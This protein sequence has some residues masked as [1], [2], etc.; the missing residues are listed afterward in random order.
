MVQPGQFRSLAEH[1][2]EDSAAALRDWARANDFLIR[3]PARPWRSS[4]GYSGAT[5]HTIVLERDHVAE[6]L[7]VKR[8][9]PWPQRIHR[10]QPAGEPGRHRYALEHDPSDFSRDHL[11]AQ[12]FPAIMTSAGHIL[13]FQALAADGLPCVSLAELAPAVLPEA[14]ALVLG[15]LVGSWNDHRLR[16][17]AGT[18]ATVLH[19]EVGGTFAAGGTV[20]R[21]A[22]RAALLDIAVDWITLVGD[23]R[24]FPNPVLLALG[25][26]P[27][28][29]VPVD[30]V[31]GRAHGDL[32]L[33]NV[34]V[35]LAANG[36][37]LIPEF[38]I[39]DLA[40]ACTSGCL[41]RDLLTLMLS[42]I[43]LNI[44]SLPERRLDELIDHVL[45]A[46]GRSGT[47][48]AFRV[49]TAVCTALQ[50]GVSAAGQSLSGNLKLQRLLSTQA[51]SLAFTAYERLS[52]R[53]RWWF[54]RLSCRAGLRL[55]EEID[56]GAF[57]PARSHVLDDPFAPAAIAP[58]SAEPAP[59]TESRASLDERLL[60]R[61]YER[62]E[63]KDLDARDGPTQLR[64][65]CERS[66]TILGWNHPLTLAFRHNLAL[67]LDK[68]GSAKEAR[69]VYA[70]T[71]AAARR[72]LGDGHQ[73]TMS[74]ERAL[75]SRTL[76]RRA[77]EE[78]A[79]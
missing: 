37:A 75:G 71:Y 21:W 58:D 22:E 51:I 18:V 57:I 5:L 77:E 46:G 41:T 38:R 34:L 61:E 11:V 62:I 29:E 7:I 47:E 3:V 67:R 52:P 50:D 31:R 13:M 40:T 68:T 10:P 15:G 19:E 36:K 35:P 56:P 76:R 72:A 8:I 42:A 25:H 45:T 27:Y 23:R 17:E 55:V 2:G 12:P 16:L 4:D 79:G 39:I 49:V 14:C 44:D 73:I 74:C 9:P 78:G 6:Q 24:T 63:H 32:H 70:Q 43:A 65:L 20:R 69:E 30:V 53:T 48:T 28:R 64:T 26:T 33:L 54:L 66:R 1:L 60:M 59:S